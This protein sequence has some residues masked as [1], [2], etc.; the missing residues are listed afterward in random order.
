MQLFIELRG[1][2]RGRYVEKHG[3]VHERRLAALRPQNVQ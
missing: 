3:V 2:S 1:W